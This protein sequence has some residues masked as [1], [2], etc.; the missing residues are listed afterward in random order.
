M[1]ARVTRLVAEKFVLSTFPRAL[2]T[3]SSMCSRAVRALE[4]SPGLI[5]MMDNVEETIYAGP[6]ALSGGVKQ[7]LV[8]VSREDL[9]NVD[10]DLTVDSD[11]DLLFSGGVTYDTPVEGL[12]FFA[13]YAQ[14][15]KAFS[16][17]LLEVPGR[18]LDLLE[19][20]TASNID[21]GLQYS[22]DRVALSATWYTIDFENRIFYLGPQT[23][24]GP[25][26]LIPGGGAYFNAGG[27]DTSGIELSATVQMPH[28]TS[29][30]TAFTFND[31]EYIGSG[32]SPRRREPGHR[33]GH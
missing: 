17:T 1:V 13:G 18:S 8:G 4:S 23:P 11:S 28:R 12:D 27:I 33:G 24:A 30:Y 2:T 22:G 20:E 9:F 7:F 10:P 19:P 3:L 15:F 5:M 26:Y 14:N 6:F 29:F 31:S 25:N 21:I 32:D 16:S